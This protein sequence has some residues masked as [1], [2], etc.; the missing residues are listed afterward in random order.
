MAQ[1]DQG[2]E[3]A[4]R[5]KGKRQNRK[6][7]LCYCFVL[8]ISVPMA[9][10]CWAQQAWLNWRYVRKQARSMG[11]MNLDP[12]RFVE[13]IWYIYIYTCIYIYAAIKCIRLSI[14]H[15]SL[16]AM[17]LMKGY[18]F[19]DIIQCV[20]L[21]HTVHAAAAATDDDDDDENQFF[22]YFFLFFS[23][24]GRFRATKLKTYQ[25]FGGHEWWTLNAQIQLLLCF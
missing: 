1:A 15:F 24:V 14:T 10:V 7:N 23:F 12:N 2:G 17:K 11:S 16:C 18:I 13:A 25:T 6:K 22:S 9:T 8:C 21:C 3:C 4:A 5:K 20:K 19:I